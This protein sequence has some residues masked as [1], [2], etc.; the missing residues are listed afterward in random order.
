[1]KC[2]SCGWISP[3][4]SDVE[5]CQSCGEDRFL[6]VLFDADDADPVNVVRGLLSYPQ[7]F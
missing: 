3:N 2:D 4:V 1:M 5:F 6:R 7:L